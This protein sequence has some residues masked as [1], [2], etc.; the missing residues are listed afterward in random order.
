[1]EEGTARFL[2]ETG[3]IVES[4]FA[5][6]LWP[7]IGAWWWAVLPLALFPPAT[8]WWL[9][10]RRLA[11]FKKRKYTL[12]EI[13][14]PEDLKK[15]IKAMEDVFNSMYMIALEHGP[16]TNREKWIDGM[17]KQFTTFSLEIVGIDGE[18]HFYIRIDDFLQDLVES[19]LY[20][21]FPDLQINVVEDYTK[22]V[23]EHIPNK[24][25]ELEAM[26]W[27]LINPSPYPIKTYKLFEAEQEPKEE[28]RVDPMARLIEA[29][30]KIQKGE[31]LWLQ[32][33]LTD[34]GSGWIK[35]GKAIRDKLVKRPGPKPGL[36]PIFQEAAELV[37]FGMKEK[38]EKKPE[39]M[40]YPEMLTTPG[41]R[42]VVKAIEEKIAKNGFKIS[43]RLI[44]LAKR[45]VFYK[46]HIALPI[47]F[48][49]SFGVKGLNYFIPYV[50]SRTKVKSLVRFF[51]KKKAFLKKRKIMRN[52]RWRVS[53]LFPEKGATSIVNVEELATLFHFPS[54]L[55]A[56]GV[57]LER[58]TAKTSG[59][60]QDLPVE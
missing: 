40:L 29:L 42:E 57:S 48:I 52:Y 16:G 36:K 45:D 53:P 50:P 41:E 15:P 7:I 12:L 49:C 46:P 26:D 2:L 10:W 37:V 30:S 14:L 56:P 38:E 11:Y 20:A 1:M 3:G 35:E 4:F 32:F 21:Q 23:P 39:M 24:E 9:K 43:M 51:D 8:R 33:N 27:E 34:A 25:W 22:K 31:Q 54:M 58:L 28:K 18:T 6:L 19:I 5:D 60:P 13:K 55:A 17:D 44:Y 59:P 47:S